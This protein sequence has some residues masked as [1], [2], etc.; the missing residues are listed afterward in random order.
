VRLI[1][2]AGRRPGIHVLPLAAKKDVD[3]GAKPRHDDIGRTDPE[4]K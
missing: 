1:R 2:H 4:L 3:G